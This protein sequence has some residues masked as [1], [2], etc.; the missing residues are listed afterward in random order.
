M[1]NIRIIPQAQ[2]DLNALRGKIFEQI[3]QKI[4]DLKKNPRLIGCE[5]LT[6]K[7]GYRV[8]V[9]DFRILY[10]ICDDIKKVIIYRI[11]HRREAYR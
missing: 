6:R 4:I 5:K 2:K 1:Y 10:K 3:K 7:E 9:R 8:R 11:K